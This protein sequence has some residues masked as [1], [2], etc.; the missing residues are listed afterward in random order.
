MEIPRRKVWAL[1]IYL[2]MTGETQRR[3]ALATLL[4]PTYAQSEARTALTRHL[5]EL[6]KISAQGFLNSSRETVAL[7]GAIWLDVAEFQQLVADCTDSDCLARLTAAVALYRDDFLRGFTLPDSPDFDEWQFFQTEGLRQH[8]AVAL[9]RLSL[10]HSQHSNYEAAIP[11]ARRWLALDPLHEPAHRHLMHLLADSGQR[12]A[13][14]HQYETC[15]RLLAAELKVVPDSATVALAEQIRSGAIRRR[16]AQ[17]PTRTVSGHPTAAAPA[18]DQAPRPDPA[19]ILS[20]LAPLADQ[21]L[22]GIETARQT[23][24]PMLAAEERPWLIAIDG[25][26]GI[27]KTTLANNLVREAL[28]GGRFGDM[29][30]VSAKQEEFL[31]GFGMRSTNRPAL[32]AEQLTDAL[33]AQLTD[34]SSLAIPSREKGVLLQQR[35]KTVP[36][37]VVVDNLETVVDY[38]A[39]VP[40]LRQLTNPTKFLL[41]SRLSLQ[42]YTDVFCYSLGELNETDTLAFLC[43][44][45]ERRGIVP[46][47]QATPAQLQHIYGVVGGNPLALKLVMGQVRF[48]PLEQVLENLQ[49]AQ[50]RQID[51]LYT[52][53]YWQIW[54]MLD[55]AARRLMLTLPVMPNS[56]FGQLAAISELDRATLQ[57][58][59]LHLIDHSLVQV[60]GDLAEPR[61]RLHRL[62]ETFLIH[63]VLTWQ[64]P[65]N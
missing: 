36:T 22:F 62:T 4:W 13:A 25:I 63:E 32:D 12:S 7:T 11:H 1:L 39:L 40:F 9:E 46:L 55:E 53:I 20:R 57:S 14:L 34:A 27:G 5:S 65:S 2:A 29:A 26:G 50:G 8:L 24:A 64:P 3:D 18:M 38:Q 49:F 47:Q 61:Y 45:A 48:L 30:W 58:A 56:T 17:E 16:E 10:L 42:A 19:I 37:L 43:Y 21:K 59:L 15:C 52:Y 51:E 23:V 60:A 33:L 6:R 44:E 28:T 54:Q 41:T 35:L 31:P